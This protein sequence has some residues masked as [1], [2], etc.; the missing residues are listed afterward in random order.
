MRDFT[1]SAIG[2]LALSLPAAAIL[3]SVFF[4]CGGVVWT[5]KGTETSR[6]KTSTEGVDE[7]VYQKQWEYAVAELLLELSSVAELQ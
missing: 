3:C 2:K 5:S 6:G 4:A 1:K 7:T